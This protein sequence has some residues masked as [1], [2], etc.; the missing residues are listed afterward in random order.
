MIPNPFVTDLSPGRLHLTLRTRAANDNVPL[1]ATSRRSPAAPRRAE[2]NASTL[3]PLLRR[4][5]IP[6]CVDRNSFFAKLGVFPAP[7]P[8][9]GVEAGRIG[10]VARP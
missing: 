2:A 10:G 6:R 1:E 4:A 9:L 7:N 5:L 8:G 3:W